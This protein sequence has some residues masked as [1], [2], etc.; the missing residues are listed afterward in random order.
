MTIETQSEVA[1]QQTIAHF[2]AIGL[3][4]PTPRQINDELLRRVLL[5]QRLLALEGQTTINRFNKGLTNPQIE[6]IKTVMPDEEQKPPKEE[7]PPAE[8]DKS[9]TTP[10]SPGVEVSQLGPIHGAKP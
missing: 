4:D 8:E 9:Q 1:C 2:K 3:L 5:N 6:R 10:E 7:T